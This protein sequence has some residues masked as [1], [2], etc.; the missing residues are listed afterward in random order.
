VAERQVGPGEPGDALMT[1]APNATIGRRKLRAAL[2][3]AREESGYTQEHAAR[4]LDWSLS[5]LIRIEA[6]IVGLSTVDCKAL[7]DL[8]G[9][10]DA[11]QIGTLVELARVSRRKPWWFEHKDS[12][13]P[14]FTKYLGLEAG[15][16][17][18]RTFQSLTVPGLFQTPEYAAE[19]TGGAW[20]DPLSDETVGR[21]VQ[22]RLARQREVF[23]RA[24]PPTLVSVLDEGVLRRAVGSSEVMRGQLTHLAA[25]AEQ[26]NVTVLVVPF[27]AGVPVYLNSFVVLSFPDPEDTDVV[28]MEGTSGQQV[29]EDGNPIAQY[30]S[31]FERLVQKSL[32]P[33]ESVALIQKVAGELD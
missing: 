7:L 15:A 3:R 31:T 21:M 32:D 12:L 14:V 6:G 4:A 29:I 30:K 13:D 19:V 2:R 10:T 33:A 11:A 20:V 17:T 27:S 1:T 9:V 16:S 22:V 5:K 28:Y 24:E 23:D 18:L 26:P 8:Y 25:L